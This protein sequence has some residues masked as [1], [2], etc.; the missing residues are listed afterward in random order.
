VARALFG[1]EVIPFL[2]G[3]VMALHPV[4]VFSV[5]RYRCIHA[6]N[7]YILLLCC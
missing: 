5:A 1:S 4:F 6:V 2:V 7:V 3:I